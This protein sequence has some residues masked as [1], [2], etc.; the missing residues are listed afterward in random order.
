MFPGVEKAFASTIIVA[1]GPKKHHYALSRCYNSPIID[2]YTFNLFPLMYPYV[3]G[4]I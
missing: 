2:P 1:A 4:S 3:I